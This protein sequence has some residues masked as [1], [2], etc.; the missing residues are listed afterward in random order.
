MPVSVDLKPQRSAGPAFRGPHSAPGVELVIAVLIFCVG[1]WAGVRAVQAFRTAGGAQYFYQSD[2]GPAVMLA[3]GR[4]FL[5]PDTRNAPALVA[6]LLQQSDSVDCAS[7]PLTIPT[8]PMNAFQRG[9]RYLE[10][11]VAL[12]WK[13]T[14]LSWSRLAILPGVL[15]GAVAALTYGLLRL[16]MSRRFALLALLPSVTSTPNFMQVP[17]LR[18]YAKGPFLL[19]VILIMGVVVLGPTDRRRAIGLS[20]LAGAVV[21]LGF[22]FRA[23]LVIAVLPFAIALAFLVPP[24]VSIPAR[25]A[26]VVVFVVS[27]VVIAFPVLRDLSKGGNNG[28][29]IMLGL[30]ADFDGPLRIEP[31]VYEFGGRYVDSL[32]FTTIDSYAIRVEGHA[33]DGTSAEYERAAV[34]YLGR[35]AATFPADVITRVAAAIRAVPKYFLDSSLYAPVQV[36]SSEFAGDVYRLRG[37]AFW[38]LAHIA[39]VAFAA[40]TLLVSAESPRAAWLIVVVMVGFAG[41]SAI[42]FHERH[43]YYLQFLP[44][45]AFGL[46]AQAAF[47]GPTLLKTLTSDHVKRATIFAVIVAGIAG[48]GIVLSRGY[49]QRT[50]VQLFGR[51][52]AAPRS[53]LHAVTRP[54]G[55]GRTL[56]AAQDWLEALPRG[57]RS[58]ETRFIGVRFRDDLCGPGN[59]PL[60]IRY[61]GRRRDADLSEPITVRLRSGASAPTTLFVVAYDWAD[62]YIR[63]RG[64]EVAADQVHCVGEL[65]RVEGLERTPLLLTTTLGADWR[66]ERLYQR[67]H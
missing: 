48:C 30:F 41:P 45:L 51:Y 54:A 35:V 43:F 1:T 42:Q 66:E 7:V 15:F 25:L 38:R 27:F 61:D 50:A 39:F 22:G 49:Q 63:F 67:L 64:I 13:I 11:A 47:D 56:I 14:G 20:A 19:A 16:A 53:P 33:V 59:L 5:D 18:D 32:A 17:Q 23:D 26:A 31:S 65:S 24:T 29:V 10:F 6:F 21:G 8:T 44:W 40:A 60:T 58:I 57:G 2:F 55:A 36:Q 4:E 12:T 3:C 28:H 37:R 46:L 62:D 52:E 9:I 34:A